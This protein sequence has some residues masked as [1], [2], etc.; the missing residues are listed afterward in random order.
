LAGRS[1]V[2]KPLVYIDSRGRL[3]LGVNQAN[4][5]QTGSA[6]EGAAPFIPRKVAP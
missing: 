4:F 1:L 5:A 3:S 6:G 2:G